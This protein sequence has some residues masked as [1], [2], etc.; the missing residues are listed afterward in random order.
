MKQLRKSFPPE[1]FRRMNVEN[2]KDSMIRFI[3]EEWYKFY[4]RNRPEIISALKEETQNTCAY[5]ETRITGSGNLDHIKPKSKFP[6]LVFDWE[7]ITIACSQCNARKSAKE[8]SLN[9][10]ETNPADHLQFTKDGLVISLSEI[11]QEAID[12]LSLN[13]PDLITDR[14]FE[15]GRYEKMYSRTSSIEEGINLVNAHQGCVIDVFTRDLPN[16]RL[17][18]DHYWKHTGLNNFDL[19][20]HDGSDIEKYKKKRIILERVEIDNF[21]AI[22][23]LTISFSNIFGTKAPCLF[24]I[25]ENG[26]GKSSILKAIALTLLGKNSFEKHSFLFEKDACVRIDGK[27]NSYQ[28]SVRLKLTD[29][30]DDPIIEF[31]N[32]INP[33]ISTS[34]RKMPVLAYGSTRILSDSI[35]EGTELKYPGL[36]IINLFDQR[37]ELVNAHKWLMLLEEDEF[38]SIANN[39]LHDILLLDDSQFI[40]RHIKEESIKIEPEGVPIQSWSDGYKTV[41]SLICDILSNMRSIWGEEV[42][43]I[44]DYSGIVIIDEVELHLHPKWKQ[45]I[46]PRLRR[47]FPQIQFIISTHDPLCIQNALQ[48]EVHLVYRDSNNKICISQKDAPKGLIIDNYLTGELFS[49]GTTIDEDTQELIRDYQKSFINNQDVSE[50]KDQLTERF[51]SYADSTFWGIYNAVL[52]DLKLPSKVYYDDEEKKRIAKSIKELLDN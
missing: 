12:I 5:C 46:V 15:I 22:D 43:R 37:S 6:E 27:G 24:I 25:G 33:N 44:N 39:V 34:G 2:Y 35:E 26:C 29:I 8:I 10:F 18:D 49:M 13:R 40:N 48:G 17:D 30:E 45:E 28:G 41:M 32:S 1:P 52:N 16:S 9:P 20:I 3:K 36:S 11:G 31:S 23:D 7:N 4:S 38:A 47:I 19:D 14:K 50:L 42:E 51:G 21:K